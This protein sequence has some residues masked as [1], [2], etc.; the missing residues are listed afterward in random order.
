MTRTPVQSSHVAAIA[1]DPHTQVLEVE[2][3]PDRS[4][5]AAV[6]Q[7]VPVAPQVAEQ[8]LTPGNSVGHILHES[9][10]KNASVQAVNVTPVSP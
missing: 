8:M 2:F 5:R 9:V 4:G 7:Y 6:W 3:K 10:R 1:Y